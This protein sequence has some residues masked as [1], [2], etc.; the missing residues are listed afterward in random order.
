MKQRAPRT[1]DEAQKF[2]EGMLRR[3]ESFHLTM[4]LSVSLYASRVSRGESFALCWFDSGSKMHDF[5]SHSITLLLQEFVAWK[6]LIERPLTPAK[7]HVGVKPIKR[8]E[9]KEPVSLCG[10]DPQ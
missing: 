10:E 3:D 7:A 5:R 4:D 6:S 1:I 8:L 9:H 2:L